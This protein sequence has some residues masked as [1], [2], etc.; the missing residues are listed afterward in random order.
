M[1]LLLFFLFKQPVLNKM[2]KKN[3]TAE[4]H[5]SFAILKKKKLDYRCECAAKFYLCL[6]VFFP[7][8]LILGS[9]ILDI[10]EKL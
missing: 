3:R 5:I 1:L 10:G 8:H 2:E 6:S 9:V 7:W 4:I